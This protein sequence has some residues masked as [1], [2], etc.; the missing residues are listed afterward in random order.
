VIFALAMDTENR[1]DSLWGET[2]IQAEIA[3]KQSVT[4]RSR[5]KLRHR[6][7]GAYPKWVYVSKVFRDSK[8]IHLPHFLLL[9]ARGGFWLA[10]G[11]D[12]LVNTDQK[13]SKLEL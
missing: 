1:S 7:V 3:P 8:W 11:G 5:P 2:S 12:G 9:A 6:A 13:R 4:V 10:Y